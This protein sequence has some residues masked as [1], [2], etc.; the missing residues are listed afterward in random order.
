M[1]NKIFD[2]IEDKTI[3]N[4]T[5][6]ENKRICITFTTNEKLYLKCEEMCFEGKNDLLAE[7]KY[8]TS[9]SYDD[10]KPRKLKN[11]KLNKYKDS[12]DFKFDYI[13]L[14][15]ILYIYWKYIGYFKIEMDFEQDE[16]DMLREMNLY[17]LEHDKHGSEFI[18]IFEKAINL[19]K[20]ERN[21]KND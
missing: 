2:F 18:I 7:K 11:I 3:L 1:R 9:I 19:I 21:D 5:K 10:I 6:L 4:I 14:D 15:N 13:F 20:K 16:V 8:K 17:L 12:R